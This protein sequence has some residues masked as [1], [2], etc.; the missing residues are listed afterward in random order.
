MMIFFLF[1]VLFAVAS[2][3]FQILNCKRNFLQINFEAD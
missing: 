2:K 1:G 3:I